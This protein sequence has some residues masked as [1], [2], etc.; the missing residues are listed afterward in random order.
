VQTHSAGLDREVPHAALSGGEP[1]PGV[2]VGS[3]FQ[4]GPVLERGLQRPD[5]QACV[6]MGKDDAL[7]RQ[8]KILQTMNLIPQEE[9]LQN[10][11]PLIVMS[12][13]VL[14]NTVLAQSLPA[15]RFFPPN[16]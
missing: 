3:Q 11:R 6:G 12:N 8:D 2:G 9:V 5:L 10:A 7:C 4:R 1:L 14:H 16:K 13:L 15:G